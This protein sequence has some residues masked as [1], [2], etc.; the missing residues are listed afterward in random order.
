MKTIPDSVPKSLRKIVADE[1]V[2]G[3]SNE[4]GENGY[5]IFLKGWNWDGFHAINEHGVKFMLE[6]FKRIEQCRPGCECEWDKK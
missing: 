3:W 2:T 6:E 5:W 4:A 1:R